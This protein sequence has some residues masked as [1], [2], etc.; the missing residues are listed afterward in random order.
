[1]LWQK[2][3][4]AQ[5]RRLFATRPDTAPEA[6]G[7]AQDV[8]SVQPGSGRWRQA[9]SGRY[10]KLFIPVL[11]LYGDIGDLHTPSSSGAS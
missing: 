4:L 6:S 8:F 10:G 1:M 7:A 2:R 9:A 5:P 3:F 11:P